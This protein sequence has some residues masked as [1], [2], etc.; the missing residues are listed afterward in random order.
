MQAWAFTLKQFAEMY[1]EKFKIKE[2][3]LMQRLWGDNFY[4][5]KEKTWSHEKTKTNVRAFVQ[6]VFD[7]INRVFDVCMNKPLEETMAIVEKLGIKLT[8]EEQELTGKELLKTV[9]RKWL[10]AGDTLL[11]MIAIHLPSPVTAQR[12]RTELLYEG[13]ADDEAAVAIRN[14]DPQG[15]LMM[16]ISKMVPSLDRGRFYAFG[17]VFSGTV[18][19]QQKVRIMGPNYTVGKKTDLTIDKIQR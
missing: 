6:F 3:K 19:S 2:E 15:P 4:D 10:P 16:Y 18:S 8:K 12:Y 7:P 13:P 11:Q 9:M 17:R 5:T 14:C 1:A